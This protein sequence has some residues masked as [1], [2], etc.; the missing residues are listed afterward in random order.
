MSQHKIIKI[1]D[2]VTPESEDFLNQLGREGWEL[3]H[4]YNQH[5]YLKAAGAGAYS[6]GGNVNAGYDAFGRQRIAELYTLGDYKSPYGQPS[7][8]LLLQSS[9][10]A[11]ITP[12]PYRSSNTIAV[13]G[14]SGS[15]AV[16]QSRKYHNYMPGKSQLIYQSF[17]MGAAVSGS[18]KRVG[19][20]DDNNGIFLE[21]DQTGSLH[22]V[23]R[24]NASGQIDEHRVPQTQWNINTLLSGSFILDLTKVQLIAIDFQ[25]LGVG[26]VR[27]GF[28]Y[29][30]TEVLT[31]V[32]DHTNQDTMVYMSQ[33][34]LPVRGEVR[35]ALNGSTGSIEFI[36]ASVQ[37][38][39]GFA[40]AG[41][42]WAI[43]TTTLQSVAS[44][45]TKGI[46]A[47]RLKNTYN[48]YANRGYVIPTIAELY[49]TDR[50]QAYRLIK[51]PNKSYI[52]T[53]STWTSVND[54]SIVEYNTNISA[55]TDGREILNG[56]VAASGT[57]TG[58]FNSARD[59]QLGNATIGNFMA[60][61]YDST[62]SEIY[63]VVAK[64][65]TA[66]A[67]TVGAG[68]QWQEIY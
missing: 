38:E 1:P 27:C 45:S 19:Y 47:I 17:L 35:S 2:W 31:H 33:P 3:V 65:L 25:W 24:S 51:L 16:M 54:E 39:G 12:N 6:D 68:M 14:S 40:E 61:N 62:D 56:F 57:G 10:G 5:A 29:K 26:R 43:S 50:S 42:T 23:I 13:S 9:S 52:T 4:L 20:F 28:S 63:L 55:F 60:Q 30:G 53:G 21:Q 48:G 49:A 8:G 11:S 37:S 18:I 36:C 22:W 66:D 41:R 59:S 34:N 32:F 46:L 44:G 67:T 7:M 58:N 15:Y 64:N